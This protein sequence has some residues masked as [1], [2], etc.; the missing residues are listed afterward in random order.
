VL[1]YS[2]YAYIFLTVIPRWL[3]L[4]SVAVHV[5]MVQIAKSVFIYLGIPF[6]AAI[7]TRTAMVKSRG[8]DWYEANFIPR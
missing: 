7:I 5:S 6:I 3:G 1:T 2:V 8:R 4:S